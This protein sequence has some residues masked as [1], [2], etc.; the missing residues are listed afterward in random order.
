VEEAPSTLVEMDKMVLK[1]LVEMVVRILEE[2]GV[3]VLMKMEMV[4]LEG[5]VLLL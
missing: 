2:G 5:Q 3:A 4:V 1:L